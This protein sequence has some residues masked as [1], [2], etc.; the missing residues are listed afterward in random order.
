MAEGLSATEVGKEIGGHA[1][2]AH[3]EGDRRDRLISIAE[4]L[5]LSIVAIVAAWSGYSAAK[6]GTE[7]SL[8]L[9]KASAIRT[10][11]N[12]E[13]LESFTVRAQDASNFNAW[14][15]AY[16]A[17]DRTGQRVAERR[18]RPGYDVAFRAWL[19]THPFTDPKAP[20]GPQ[21]M[22][23]YHP[24]GLARSVALNAKADHLYAA[25]AKAGTT[26]DK[27][28]RV[29][30]ILASVLFIV[31]ISGHFRLRAARIGLVC[32]GTALLVLAAIQILQLPRPPA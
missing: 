21:Y 24:P 25:G 12:G 27:Y 30:V 9:A 16:L 3:S 5:L 4:A 17:H 13:F 1:A 23:Q 10:K 15:S 20:K 8:E 14:L 2:H 19:E 22:P 18:F 11:A 29:T 6:W 32:V 31:G 28:V 7:S 26:G